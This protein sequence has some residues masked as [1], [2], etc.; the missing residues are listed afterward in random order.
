MSYNEDYCHEHIINP[1]LSGSCPQCEVEYLHDIIQKIR[2][3]II[4]FEN[5]STMSD[6]VIIH[7]IK[8]IIGEIR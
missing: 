3:A 1:V 4:E 6:V 5:A 8:N 2:L 7:I